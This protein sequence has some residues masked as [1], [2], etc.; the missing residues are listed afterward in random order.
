MTSRSKDEGIQIQTPSSNQCPKVKI[1]PSE[2]S[3]YQHN[4][5]T[6]RLLEAVMKPGAYT[7]TI[8]AGGNGVDGLTEAA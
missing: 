3:L 4:L 8:F 6:E 5:F 1:V 7:N 2:G